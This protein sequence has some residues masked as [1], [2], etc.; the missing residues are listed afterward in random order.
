MDIERCPNPWH[1]TSPGRMS[2]VCPECPESPSVCN[3]DGPGCENPRRYG[4]PNGHT[5]GT[6]YARYY[7]LADEGP[8]SNV[9]TREEWTRATLGT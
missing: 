8:G 3:L 2:L 5:S 6:C 9:M 1:T 4:N 7:E